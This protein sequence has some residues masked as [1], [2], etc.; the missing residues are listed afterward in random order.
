M[1][2]GQTATIVATIRNSGTVM[3]PP[4]TM[5]LFTFEQPFL[6]S[7]L[8]PTA[9]NGC[10]LHEGGV[11]WPGLTP[12]DHRLEVTLT[13]VGRPANGRDASGAYE[14]LFATYAEPYAIAGSGP[15]YVSASFAMGTGA[16]VINPS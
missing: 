3:S 8:K 13:A 10:Q 4:I 11:E 1:K 6:G 12:G 5:L 9:C 2:V 14:W 7:F 15:I 16:T